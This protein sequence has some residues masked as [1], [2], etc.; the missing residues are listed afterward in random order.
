MSNLSQL[1][2]LQTSGRRTTLD[3]V[4]DK[5]GRGVLLRKLR[6]LKCAVH[7]PSLFVDMLE[8]RL[9]SELGGANPR[10]P[11]GG[12][13]RFYGICMASHDKFLNTQKGL[14]GLAFGDDMELVW[15]R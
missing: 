6:V 2:L 9:L 12:I 7:N 1:G 3:N 15:Y 13:Q 10:R 14:S 4:L 11:G 5:L 8:A